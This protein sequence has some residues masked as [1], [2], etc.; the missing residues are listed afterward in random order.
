MPLE[1]FL[2]CAVFP[3]RNPSQKPKRLRQILLRV[4]PPS[5]V[6]A[7]RDLAVRRRSGHR[8]L[9]WASR[10]YSTCR[11]GGPLVAGRRPARSVPPS[12]FGYPRGG[13]LPPRPR[14]PCFMP[15]A[16][17]GFTLRSLPLP[18][19]IPTLAPES[20]HLPFVLALRPPT[21]RRTGPPSRDFWASALTRVPCGTTNV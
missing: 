3:R 10:P 11:I 1:P 6:H 19:G 18:R 21:R 9:S 4:S 8:L 12:G 14:R 7:R 13:L 17:L 20:T 15:T 5:R 2:G 16:L